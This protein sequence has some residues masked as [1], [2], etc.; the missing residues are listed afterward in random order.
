[1]PSTEWE[2]TR[3]TRTGQYFRFFSLSDKNTVFVHRMNPAKSEE[4]KRVWI[5][6]DVGQQS[7]KTRAIVRQVAKTAH[8]KGIEHSARK[9]TV[10][11]D[12]V[13]YDEH[14]FNELPKGLSTESIKTQE[15]DNVV[16]HQLEHAPFSSLYP[17]NFTMNDYSYEF[18]E[19]GF[20]HNK[21]RIVRN[22]SAAKRIMKSRDVGEIQNIGGMLQKLCLSIC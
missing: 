15:F 9:Y 6:K 12:K 7:R 14:N 22:E 2:C 1:M 3:N 18:L 10:V 19:Q 4:F 13:R 5:N 21:A 20:M 17:A 8:K 11:I 16:A